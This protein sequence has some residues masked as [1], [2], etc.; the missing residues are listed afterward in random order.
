[1]YFLS[2]QICVFGFCGCLGEAQSRWGQTAVP[3]FV[4]GLWGGRGWGAGWTP[5]VVAVYHKH[6]LAQRGPSALI[7][8]SD[9]PQG[10]WAGVRI[11]ILEPICSCR[12]QPRLN[13]RTL[14]AAGICCGI[15][16]QEGI[17]RQLFCW[18]ILIWHFWT[19]LA[20]LVS[21]LTPN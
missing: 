18:Q 14:R 12:N 6:S 19:Q 2:F 15:K 4:A 20:E 16:L 10:P 7:L 9:S 1:M 21:S 3:P 13:Y 5:V 8:F 17:V 11:T